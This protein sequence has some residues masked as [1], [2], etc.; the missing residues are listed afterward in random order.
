MRT[1]KRNMVKI[2]VL[3]AKESPEH[4]TSVTDGIPR[5]EFAVKPDD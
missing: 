2:S 5:K 4:V 3:G 1:E